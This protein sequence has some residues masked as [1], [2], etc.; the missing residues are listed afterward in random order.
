MPVN[1]VQ[2]NALKDVRAG[3]LAEIAAADAHGRQK[4]H[5][6][7]R[8]DFALGSPMMIQNA[9]LRYLAAVEALAGFDREHGVLA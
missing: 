9:K 5:H 1:A 7:S 3:L 4:L 8:G 2:L 6:N